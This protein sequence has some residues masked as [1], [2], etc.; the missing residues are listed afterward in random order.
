MKLEASLFRSL[1][2]VIQLPWHFHHTQMPPLRVN[3]MMRLQSLV[4]WTLV[5]T[6]HVFRAHVWYTVKIYPVVYP[7]ALA[8]VKGCKWSMPFNKVVRYCWLNLETMY[9]KVTAIHINKITG[10]LC[11][12]TNSHSLL[13]FNTGWNTSHKEAMIP[14]RC[15]GLK[16]KLV[17]SKLISLKHH[18]AVIWTD[19]WPL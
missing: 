3:W 1:Q 5:H 4:S 2:E 12:L 7:E 6:E 18:L 10:Y 16:R 11:C 19:Q 15:S 8:N 17:V 13:I 14:R 9:I